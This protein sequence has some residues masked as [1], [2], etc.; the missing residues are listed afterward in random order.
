[1]NNKQIVGRFAPSPTGQLHFGSL[2]TAVASYCHIKSLSPTSKWLVRIEDTDT[3][4]C[5]AKFSQSILQDLSNL[6]LHWDGEVDYQ[7]KHTAI[8]E[9]LLYHVFKDKVYACQCSR[10]DLQG[11]TI[12]PRYCLKK[13]LD[14]ESHKLRIA[15]PNKMLQFNDSILGIQRQNPQ[16]TLGDMVIRRAKVSAKDRAI[17]NYIFAVSIDDVLQ[18]VTHVMRGLDILPMTSAQI[19]IMDMLHTSQIEPKIKNWYHLPLVRNESGQKLSKQNLAKPIDTSNEKKCS[20][21]LAQALKFLQ[22]P[23]VEMDTPTN[24]VAQAVRQWDNDSIK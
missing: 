21:L 18:E 10:K 6:G 4:R 12:Y 5:K 14:W 24:M 3:Q 1:M 8:Y 16:Q 20:E 22:Q 23:Q 13:M 7:S 15:L 2:T 9:E 19:A 17:F 11:A